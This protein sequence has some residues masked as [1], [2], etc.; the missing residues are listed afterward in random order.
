MRRQ[1]AKP[2][3]CTIFLSEDPE[4]M[5][6]GG[7]TVIVKSFFAACRDHKHKV[8]PKA[9]CKCDGCILAKRM[10]AVGKEQFARDLRKAFD[11]LGA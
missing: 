8:Y 2:C 3:G 11:E 10:A 7:M 9:R 1:L 5:G 6:E 4:G